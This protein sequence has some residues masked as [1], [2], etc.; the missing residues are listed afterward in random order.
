MWST[1]SHRLK[2]FKDSLR[3][4]PKT[5]RQTRSGNGRESVCLSVSDFPLSWDWQALFEAGD[6]GQN[7]RKPLLEK[8][9]AEYV[10]RLLFALREGTFTE[11]CV[12]AA[13]VVAGSAREQPNFLD[14]RWQ[15]D[16]FVELG[17]LGL[18][19]CIYAQR[20]GC[21]TDWEP[22]VWFG[23]MF[24]RTQSTMFDC[25]GLG[26]LV[27]LIGECAEEERAT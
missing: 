7:L 11:P 14:R 5:D 27:Q 26:A 10:A 4:D 18:A 3:E 22:A 12:W 20:S 23:K 25:L 6:L 17:P 19:A 16:Q 13:R 15:L 9:P 1:L 21:S 2:V 8:S 24:K